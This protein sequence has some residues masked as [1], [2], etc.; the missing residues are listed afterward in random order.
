MGPFISAFQRKVRRFVRRVGSFLSRSQLTLGER[1]GFRVL[2]IQTQAAN[3][4]DDPR[5]NML[6]QARSPR[7]PAGSIMSER[8][9]SARVKIAP[10]RF[11]PGSKK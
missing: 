9:R 10:M 4:I 1:R 7:T 2:A 11:K 8:K 6:S 3:L 5:Y